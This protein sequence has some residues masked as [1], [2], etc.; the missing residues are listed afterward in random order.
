MDLQYWSS[1]SANW[2]TTTAHKSSTFRMA[3]VQV[4]FFSILTLHAERGHIFQHFIL[5]FVDEKTRKK[6]T[7]ILWKFEKTFFRNLQFAHLS[8]FF[9]LGNDIFIGSSQVWKCHRKLHFFV[10]LFSC[11]ESISSRCTDRTTSHMTFGYATS[12]QTPFCPLTTL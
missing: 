4:S 12:H 6:F 8:N 11:H 2:A 7:K 10:R 3:R 1:C 9:Q 5:I